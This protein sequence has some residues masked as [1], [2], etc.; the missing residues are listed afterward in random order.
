MTTR[1]AIDSVF[2][3]V[4]VETLGESMP[5]HE[6]DDALLRA[7]ERNLGTDAWLTDLLTVAERIENERCS[8]NYSGVGIQPDIIASN[9]IKVSCGE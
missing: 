9:D 5:L 4:G 8:A 3:F 2:G 6:P 7:Q 1:A